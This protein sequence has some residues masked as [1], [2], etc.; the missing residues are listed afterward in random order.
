MYRTDIT[1]GVVAS[2]LSSEMPKTTQ[3][4]L[5]IADDQKAKLVAAAKSA[6]LTTSEYILRTMLEAAT[7]QEDAG[8]WRAFVKT[9]RGEIELAELNGEPVIV[10]NVKTEQPKKRGRK[11]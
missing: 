5:R 11:A 4:Q 8:E 1:R 7:K 10:R 3:L 9:S 2:S 6:G